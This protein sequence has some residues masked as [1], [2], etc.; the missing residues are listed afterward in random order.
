MLEKRDEILK[1]YFIVQNSQHP[2]FDPNMWTKTGPKQHIN[3]SIEKIQYQS[4]I[5]INLI[6]TPNHSDKLN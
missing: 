6:L 2:F 5:V 1:V 4:S 3:K